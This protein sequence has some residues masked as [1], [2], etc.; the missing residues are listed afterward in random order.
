ME[1]G[2][3]VADIM[4]TKPVTCSQDMSVQDAANLLKKYDIRSVL[5]VDGD[6][7]GIVTDK[8]FVYRSI[9][10]GLDP[11]TA[12]IKD[13]MSPK[14]FFVAPSIDM[15][16]AVE[17]MNKFNIHHLPVL[18]NDVL[19]GYITMSNIMKVE[20]QLMEIMVEKAQIRS[21]SP[22]SPLAHLS[23]EFEPL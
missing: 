2:Y 7:K 19:V 5:V 9:A 14:K 6:F 1:T 12:K 15:S 16:E 21:L 20:P 13:I 11:T 18:D 23:E 4:T 3:T 10:V 17:M 22:N 8:D